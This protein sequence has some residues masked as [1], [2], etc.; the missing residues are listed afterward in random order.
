MEGGGHQAPCPLRWPQTE[1]NAPVFTVK[2]LL[3]RDLVGFITGQ[4]K[5]PDSLEEMYPQL[6]D[7]E[8]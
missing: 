5:D 1:A 4:L 8:S 7:M 3:Y 6:F 2:G